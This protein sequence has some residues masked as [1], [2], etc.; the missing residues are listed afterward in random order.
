LFKRTLSTA[1]YNLKTVFWNRTQQFVCPEYTDTSYSERLITPYN[2][3]SR[4]IQEDRTI[5]ITALGTPSLAE[6]KISNLTFSCAFGEIRE[7]GTGASN[8]T[9]GIMKQ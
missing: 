1:G 2:T 8:G 9:D 7:L 6:E 4:Y 3:T 5:H